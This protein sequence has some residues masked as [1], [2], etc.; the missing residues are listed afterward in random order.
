VAGGIGGVK[1]WA[2]SVPAAREPDAEE[3]AMAQQAVASGRIV[4]VG[5]TRLGRR[6]RVRIVWPLG[7]AHR[8]DSSQRAAAFVPLV[9]GG[10]ALGIL[11][12]DGPV[13]DTV[14]SARP[15]RM[16]D[17]VAREAALAL[18]RVE[19]S[20]AASRSEALKR[21]DEMKTAL[22]ASISH[23][24][25]TPL[26]GIKTAVSSLLDEVVSWSRADRLVLL[27]TI[28]SQV[29]RLDRTISDILDLNRITSGTVAPMRRRID[30]A[31]LVDETRERT[32]VATQGRRVE[33]AIPAG[34][35][36]VSDESL[37]THVLVNLVENAAKY[38]S[39]GGA[40]RL[41]GRAAGT[42]VEI[43]VEDDGPGISPSDLPLVFER[44]YRAR[45]TA[46]RVKGSGLGLAIVR[47]FVTLCG[48]SVR[49]ESSSSG[50]R[51]V[52][53]LPVAP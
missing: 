8:A 44:F 4:L 16:L 49:A 6:R 38:S 17:A 10:G 52:V 43:S 3:R 36:L 25:K 47:G 23:D 12:I 2:G 15:D 39:P 20:S 29:D 27:E 5:R 48:G 19:L 50:T 53:T 33:A 32:A 22:M 40:I 45:D 13:G 35:Y 28:D 1:A 31:D 26:A 37:V 18:E 30:V 21:A 42:N 14:F 9:I 46:G 41:V 11:R 51:F 7:L 24:L 34:L